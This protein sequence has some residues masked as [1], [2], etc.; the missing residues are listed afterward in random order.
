MA[1]HIGAITGALFLRV[2]SICNCYFLA[3]LQGSESW[4]CCSSGLVERPQFLT[5]RRCY[6]KT[7]FGVLILR[8]E[9]VGLHP[10]SQAALSFIQSEA[11]TY[12]AKCHT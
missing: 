11:S 5:S 10:L 2:L 8:Q 6:Y 9:H 3:T 1:A 7:D 4:N 12:K